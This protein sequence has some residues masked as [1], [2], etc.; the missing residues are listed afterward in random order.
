M[1][2]IYH[3]PLSF[4]ISHTLQDIPNN[5]YN[6]LQADTEEARQV[7]VSDFIGKLEEIAGAYYARMREKYQPVVDLIDAEIK[8]IDEFYE[9]HNTTLLV[10]SLK[11]LKARFL[12]WLCQLPVLSFNGSKY[13]V[14]LIKPYIINHFIN[15]KGEKTR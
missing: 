12:K 13:D 6:V 4:G 15:I 14:N 9:R 2:N 3:L 8:R 11:R 5:L 7:L 1:E 10:N